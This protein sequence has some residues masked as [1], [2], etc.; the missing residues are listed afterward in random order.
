MGLQDKH[1]RWYTKR[2]ICSEDH[3]SGTWDS[4]LLLSSGHIIFAPRALNFLRWGFLRWYKGWKKARRFFHCFLLL[5]HSRDRESSSIKKQIM[6]KQSCIWRLVSLEQ[7]VRMELVDKPQVVHASNV[8]ATCSRPIHKAAKSSRAPWAS[9]IWLS[10]SS[11]T[12]AFAALS[13]IT[14]FFSGQE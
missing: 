13:A 6:T 10:I 7:M 12:P 5:W 4:S 9:Q 11:Y 14:P 8:M 1:L 3:M 2:W